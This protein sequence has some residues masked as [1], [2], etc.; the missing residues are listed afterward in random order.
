MKRGGKNL[1]NKIVCLLEGVAY[2]Y[3]LTLASVHQRFFTLMKNLCGGGLTAL[4]HKPS[5]LLPH[6]IILYLELGGT[7]PNGIS[8]MKL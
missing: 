6:K 4:L 7:K 1:C 2:Q 5:L 3:L 8:H